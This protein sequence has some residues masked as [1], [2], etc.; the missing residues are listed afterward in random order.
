MTRN[1]LLDVLSQMLKASDEID[2]KPS[3]RACS[4]GRDFISVNMC[5]TKRGWMIGK[6]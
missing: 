3:L 2:L 6:K 4:R 1:N 5:A